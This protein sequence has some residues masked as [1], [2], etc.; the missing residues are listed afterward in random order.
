MCL[1]LAR[2]WWGIMKQGTVGQWGPA[3]S[4]LGGYELSS[5]GDSRYL[6]IISSCRGWGVSGV[7]AGK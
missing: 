2:T 4:Y 5:V 3:G 6:I 1:L 7:D